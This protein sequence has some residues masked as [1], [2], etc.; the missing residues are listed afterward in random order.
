[1]P[2]L[3]NTGDVSLYCGCIDQK[4]KELNRKL[5]R[6][7]GVSHGMEVKRCKCLSSEVAPNEEDGC[8]ADKTNVRA[9]CRCK[10]KR[11]LAAGTPRW[12]KEYEDKKIRDLLHTVIYTVLFLALTVF[13]GY[14]EF[15]RTAPEKRRDSATDGSFPCD[16]DWHFVRELFICVHISDEKVTWDEAL[17]KCHG[18][19]ASISSEKEN[20]LLYKYIEQNHGIM[21]PLWIGGQSKDD[22]AQ[23]YFLG[24]VSEIEYRW[25]DFTHWKFSKV[26]KEKADRIPGRVCLTINP[27]HEMVWNYE[28][29][30]HV[31]V[32]KEPN[33]TPKD[34]RKKYGYIC[35]GLS[36]ITKSTFADTPNGNPELLDIFNPALGRPGLKEQEDIKFADLK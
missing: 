17:F 29:Q 4:I 12:K 27:E 26:D 5:N 35:K 22:S 20:E 25:A 8:K 28:E 24:H 34:C 18:H 15:T 32:L 16:K 10:R 3:I 30:Q 14:T 1:M 9:R 13:I 6:N 11:F 31:S 2:H 36:Y 21:E 23:R 7:A 33:W 19:L